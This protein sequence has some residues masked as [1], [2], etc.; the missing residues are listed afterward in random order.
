[1]ESLLN[2]PALEGYKIKSFQHDNKIIRVANEDYEDKK[3][4]YDTEE[5]ALAMMYHIADSDNVY[6]V[7]TE[8]LVTTG[9]A[10]LICKDRKPIL[11]KF[12][13]EDD[14]DPFIEKYKR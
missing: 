14:E 10:T 4:Y 5:Q 1:M 2:D 9:Y 13:E 11:M 7:M 6:V 3:F 12:V 8:T